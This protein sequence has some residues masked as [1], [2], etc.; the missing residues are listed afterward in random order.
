MT[1][2]GAIYIDA[3]RR[4][5]DQIKEAEYTASDEYHLPKGDCASQ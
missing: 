2:A 4:I 1:D 5:F 3:C